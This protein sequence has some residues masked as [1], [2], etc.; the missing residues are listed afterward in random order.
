MPHSDIKDEVVIWRVKGNLYRL[1][2]RVASLYRKAMAPLIKIFGRMSQIDLCL[3][4]FINNEEMQG[5]VTIWVD[6]YFTTGR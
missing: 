1:R 5:A 6:D 4:L 2:D 3:V